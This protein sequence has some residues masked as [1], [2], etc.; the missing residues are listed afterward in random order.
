[1][2]SYGRF[3][4]VYD[5]FMDNVNYREWADYIIETLAQ[6][7]IR[8]GLVL[9]LGCGTGTVTEMLAD[10]GYDMIGIDNSE[11]MLAEAMEK[12]AESGHDILYLLQ[13]MQDF[14]LYGTVRAVISVCDSMNYL[15]DEED[16]EYL[17]ALVTAFFVQTQRQ[18]TILICITKGEFHFISISEF[19][20]ASM[21]SLPLVISAV[22]CTIQQFANLTFFHFELVF[23]GHGL[24]HASS[25][26][27]KNATDRFSCFK[28]RLLQHFQKSSLC[29]SGTLLIDHK[30]DFLSRH[31]V[32][33][34]NF[35][36]VCYHNSLIRKIYFLNHAFINFAFFHK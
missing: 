23:I 21:N 30:T 11:E 31:S 2:E 7:G 17:F 6:D 8:D 34:S 19:N 10:A 3:A 22:Q 5:V 18:R 35:L 1:M 4:G 9:E 36:S 24:I 27:R 14:E 12:R 15:T 26:F 29:T 32:L 33:Y 13:D 25:T 20:G 16:L 28:R